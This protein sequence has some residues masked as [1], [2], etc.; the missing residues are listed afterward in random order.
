MPEKN[1]KKC[2]FCAEEIN[3][4]AIK[5][6]HCKSD[7]IEVIE[8]EKVKKRKKESENK[9][10]ERKKIGIQVVIWI[11]IVLISI[12]IWYLTIPLVVIWYIWK[13]TKIEKNKKWKGTAI[14]ILLSIILWSLIGYFGRTPII[15]ITEPA[16]NLKIQVK[17]IEIKGAVS[18]KDS[19]VK[20][21]NLPIIVENG[22]FIFKAN[23][24]DEINKFVFIATNNNKS[25]TINI[26]INRIFT[27][28]EKNEMERT[29]KEAEAKRKEAEEARKKAK[30]EAEEAKKK[31]EEDKKVKELAEKKIWE[32]SKAGQICKAHPE[33]SKT[34]C[35]GLADNKIWIGMTIDMLKYKRGLPNS[36]N[37]SNYGYGTEWQWCWHNYTPSCFYGDDDGIIDSYN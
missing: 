32:A 26:I 18:P 20:I 25:A 9:K 30:K 5:C 13:K 17:N 12:W 2:P 6:K 22:N 16:N 37:P 21:G 10:E 7:L 24:Q 35:E 29:K 23:L 1:T 3:I 19:L 34:D 14:V 33:W 31:A 11:L 4:N 15:T 27:E 8:K 36:S 28:E